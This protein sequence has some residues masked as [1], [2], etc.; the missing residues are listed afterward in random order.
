[1]SITKKQREALRGMFDGRCAY[2]GHELGEKWHADHVEPVVRKLEFVREPGKPTTM[3]TTG[4]SWYPER[5]HISNM[6][7][8]CAPCNIRKGGEPLESFRRGMERSIEV[9][10]NNY[11]AYRHA[12]RFG[13][14]VELPAK[15][16]FH[17]ERAAGSPQERRE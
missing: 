1:M 7:P 3:R 2:C 10:R 4:E 12:L 17:F 16:V 15:V 11:S 8:A 14:I 6:M 13:L 9:M 5:D